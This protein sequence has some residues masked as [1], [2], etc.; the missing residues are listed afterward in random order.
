VKDAF[1]ILGGCNGLF[2]S[3]EWSRWADPK[4]ETRRDDI[5]CPMPYRYQQRECMNC[6][7]IR[8]RAL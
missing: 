6:G 8:E 1:Q 5:G 3:H 7:L 4:E 2:T